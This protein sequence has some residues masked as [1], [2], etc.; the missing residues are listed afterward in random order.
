[1]ISDAS[2]AVIATIVTG[3]G[4][5]IST[6]FVT[7]PL[8]ASGAFIPV[9]SAFAVERKNV[10]AIWPESRRSNPA[11]RAFLNVLNGSM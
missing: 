3:S 4:I 1:V 7:A 6:D 11:A 8:V 10:T 2:D 5:G 9:P